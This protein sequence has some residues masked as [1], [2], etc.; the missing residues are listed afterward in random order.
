M[1][2]SWLEYFA[3]MAK[4]VSEKSKDP[5]TKV[6]AIIVDSKN[7][8]AG[9]G[10]NGMPLGK[11]TFPWDKTG[12][13]LDTKYPY[14]IHAEANAILN[15]VKDVDGCEMVCTLIPCN[16]CAKLIVQAGIKKVYYLDTRE[17]EMFEASKKIFKECGVDI[18]YVGDDVDVN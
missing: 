6:G 14:V 16:E 13:W 15:S 12:D 11:D 8:I 17:G 2:N 18:E 10:Y 3:K 5:S 4:T 1:K 7:R 9:T